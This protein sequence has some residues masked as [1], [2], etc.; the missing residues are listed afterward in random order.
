MNK[1]FFIVLLLFAPLLVGANKL[2]IS[3]DRAS[4]MKCLNDASK[5][6][7][8]LECLCD[9][10]EDNLTGKAVEIDKLS[11]LITRSQCLLSKSCK[12][13]L[14]SL[15]V[16]EQQIIK[17]RDKD[18]AI[19]VKGMNALGCPVDDAKEMASTMKELPSKAAIKKSA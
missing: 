1:L 16:K 13:L 19:L 11:N 18:Y 4:Q 14:Q 5:I 7:L 17:E 3:V 8:A 10:N 9:C 15:A 12:L 2:A 6:Q